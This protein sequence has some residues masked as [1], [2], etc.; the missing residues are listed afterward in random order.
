MR[1]VQIEEEKDRAEFAERAAHHFN[2]NRWAYT[3]ASGDPK[4]GELLA[5][6]WNSENVLVVRLDESF[7]PSVYGIRQFGINNELAPLEPTNI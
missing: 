7:E 2:E 4:A 5:F 3:Y 6:R 1:I